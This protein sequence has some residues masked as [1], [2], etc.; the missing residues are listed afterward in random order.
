MAFQNKHCL[1]TNEWMKI[2][3]EEGIVK[4]DEE[5]LISFLED[6]SDTIDIDNSILLIKLY[7]N[8]QNLA[9]LSKDKELNVLYHC[10]ELVLLDD[11]F[12]FGL[13][14]IAHKNKLIIE[15]KILFDRFLFINSIVNKYDEIFI[16]N[17]KK[18]L[19]Y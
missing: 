11:K 5:V 17:L 15:Q 8:L 9:L 10:E 4:N 7:N 6:Y 16:T 12:E 13:I 19:N 14:Y 3:I 18:M 1:W 2:K